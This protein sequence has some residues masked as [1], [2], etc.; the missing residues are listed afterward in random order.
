MKNKTQYILLC[1][2]VIFAL[3]FMCFASAQ[4]QT[5]TLDSCLALARRNNVEIR[6]SQLEIQRA[7]EVKQQVFTK[8]FPQVNLAGLGYYSAQPLIHFGIDDIQSNNMR[9]LLQAVYAR[10][11]EDGA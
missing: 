7:N 8:Y 11:G 5:L 3:Q 2:S 4:A 1:A 10:G 6:T 9:E